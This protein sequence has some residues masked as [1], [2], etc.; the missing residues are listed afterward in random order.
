MPI[1][2]FRKVTNAISYNEGKSLKHYIK[3]SG[4]FTQD[5]K[6]TKLYVVH[7]NGHVEKTKRWKRSVYPGSEIIVPAKKKRE[8]GRM[9]SNQVV[10]LSSAA[11]S[12][13]TVVLTLVSVL[14]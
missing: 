11:S 8:E 13:A 7:A 3:M 14:K 1:S 12:L 10:A 5:A 2:C 4:G 6:K 9:S